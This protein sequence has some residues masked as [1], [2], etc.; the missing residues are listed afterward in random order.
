M[1]MDRDQAVTRPAR[2]ARPGA[3]SPVGPGALETGP[4]P[5]A[6]PGHASQAR[7]DTAPLTVVLQGRG[8]RGAP[9]VAKVN[10]E[11]DPFRALS[12]AA[13]YLTSVL[14]PASRRNWAAAAGWCWAAVHVLDALAVAIERGD[15]PDPW[16]RDH[17]NWRLNPQGWAP[18]APVTATF[19]AL[20]RRPGQEEAR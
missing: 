15:Q 4:Q 1:T 8:R 3:S 6:T 20:T 14:R 13:E 11:T 2:Q 18:L 9:G 12:R 5:R 19:R 17:R 16:F 10:A 7:D